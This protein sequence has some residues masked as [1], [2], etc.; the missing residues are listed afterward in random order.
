MREKVSQIIERK[1][2]FFNGGKKSYMCEVVCVI[3]AIAH[4]NLLIG[5]KK[6]GAFC[7]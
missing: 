6:A 3:I 1:Q 4:I 7:E 2:V 5:F